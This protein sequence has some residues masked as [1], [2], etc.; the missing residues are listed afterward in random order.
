MFIVYSYMFR[1]TWVWYITKTWTSQYVHTTNKY[2]YN[3]QLQYHNNDI[4]YNLQL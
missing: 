3:N 4:C 2:I 1:L